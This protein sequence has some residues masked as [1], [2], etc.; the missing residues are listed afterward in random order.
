MSDDEQPFDAAPAVEPDDDGEVLAQ[1]TRRPR[2]VTITL[3]TVV[4][5][6]L[7]TG[8]TVSGPAAPTSRWPTSTRAPGC[9]V[10]G[11]T[12]PGQRRDRP[13]RHPD[14]D[15]GL[16]QPR[17]PGRADRQV[18]DPA[19]PHHRSGE[20]ARPHHSAGQRRHAHHAGSWR[21]RG[22]VRRERL[23]HR[24]R[25]RSGAAAGPAHPGPVGE[26][27][28]LPNGITPGGFDGKGTLWIGVPTE[29]PWSASGRAPAAVTRRC[30]AP[31][32]SPRPD[33]T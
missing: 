31:S 14:E 6:V 27:I 17:D 15:Q 12:R 5:L 30:C 28:T 8:L 33:M 22:A 25:A 1:R 32:R 26:A 16:P 4:T 3:A 2:G 10:S 20:R 21:E 19:R 13:G 7:A 18:P 29:E 24:Q 11:R 23:R 9:G